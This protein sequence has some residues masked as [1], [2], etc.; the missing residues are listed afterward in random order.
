MGGKGVILDGV[1]AIL[2]CNYLHEYISLK[3]HLKP[4][5]Y[6]ETNEMKCKKLET[7]RVA[8]MD[9]VEYVERKREKW[10]NNKCPINA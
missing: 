7:Y 6:S 8:L 9:N 1:P 3:S 10:D 5:Y 2:A 4:R